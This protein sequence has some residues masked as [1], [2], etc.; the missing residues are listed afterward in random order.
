[1]ASVIH[2]V[3]IQMAT[4]N[5]RLGDS[6]N[7]SGSSHKIK[8]KSKGP[9]ARLT[10]PA[11]CDI[12]VFSTG[13]IWVKI[14]HLCILPSLT[15]SRLLKELIISIQAYFR[16]HDFI[17]SN[18]LWKWIIIPGVVYAVLFG[19]SM[20]F[21]SHSLNSAI[22]WITVETGLQKWLNRLQNSWIGFIFT[23]GG[24]IMWIIV[25][26]M[27]F[28]LFK[29]IWLIVGSP[30]F[31]FLSEKTACMLEGRTYRFNLRQ[32][33]KDV[34]RGMG[35]AIRNTFWQIIYLLAIIFVS[36]LPVIGWATPLLAIM[37]ECYYYGFSMLDYTCERR[38]YGKT[39][40]IEFISGH[41][42]LAIGNGI[43]FYLMHTIVLVGWVLAPAY[44]VIAA[45]ISLH[46][47]NPSNNK[48]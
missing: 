25:M 5:T 22:E 33:L 6:P 19:V 34:I 47:I 12:L 2:Q 9:N 21:F 38:G 18:R 15:K 31:S 24:V 13:T 11:K 7:E 16:A 32:Y 27:Y 37:I 43:I 17:R 44:A 26:L 42:G 39:Q 10:K 20:Y 36:L 8:A 3:I 14:N 28:S 23:V 40:S 30:I 4:A 48:A 45:T 46:D 41:R 35:M 29:Y 1:M